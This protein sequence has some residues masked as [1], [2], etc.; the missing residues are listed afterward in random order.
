M[1]PLAD[2][3][4]APAG[5]VSEKGVYSLT[6]AVRKPVTMPRTFRSALGLAAQCPVQVQYCSS[7]ACAMIQHWSAAEL[8]RARQCCRRGGARHSPAWSL[9]ATVRDD[10]RHGVPWW[11]TVCNGGVI[12]V[13]RRPVPT[14]CYTTASKPLKPA[15]RYRIP[16]VGQY[17][18]QVMHSM[19]HRTLA[20]L[21][22]CAATVPVAAPAVR[23]VG[24]QHREVLY[25]GCLATTTRE[26]GAGS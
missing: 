7:I 17:H 19:M 16:L 6:P 18:R 13:H 8:Y 1:W 2:G 25:S 4:Q 10:A 11:Y 26:A 5:S 14:N 20:A 3:K 12:P 15:A 9:R 24:R 21:G 23:V 22:Y